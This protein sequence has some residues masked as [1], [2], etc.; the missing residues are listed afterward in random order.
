[1]RATSKAILTC[2]VLPAVLAGCGEDFT[3]EEMQLGAGGKPRPLAILCEPAEASPGETVTVSLVWHELDPGPAETDWR[4]ALDH[5]PGMYGADVVERRIV[6]L[7][8]VVDIPDPVGDDGGFLTQTFTMTVPDSTLL[9]ASCWPEVLDDDALLL[10]AGAALPGTTG[11]GIAKADVDAFLAALTP[12]DLAAMPAAER[13]AILRLADLFACEIRLRVVLRGGVTVDVT[14]NLT[15]RHSRRLGSANVNENPATAEYA[16]VGIARPDFDWDDIDTYTGEKRRWTF[17]AGE[18]ASLEI[19]RRRGWTYYLHLTIAPQ[20]YASPTDPDRL[21]TENTTLRWYYFRLDDPGAGP[22]LFVDDAGEAT[23]MWALD[24][25]VRLQPPA[26]GAAP[27]YRVVA[28]ARD[29]RI[30]WE[31]FHA[32]PGAA[33]IE[34]EIIFVDE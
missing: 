16:V 28:C 5:D 33:L 34:G 4:V 11:E 8:Q 14:R 18:G 23:E 6:D 22:D 31:M 32:T 2:L 3:N 24:E 20:R 19:P 27:R 10:P 7:E 9:W 26:G 25:S 13:D 17:P 15:V 1:M 29:E 21:L 12:D 30:E